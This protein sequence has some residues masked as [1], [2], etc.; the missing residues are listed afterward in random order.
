M[1]FERSIPLDMDAFRLLDSVH[2]NVCAELGI[3]PRAVGGD[4]D[5]AMRRVVSTAIVKAALEGERDPVVLK[6]CAH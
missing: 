4:V 3:A 6:A 5:T 2:A 1:P